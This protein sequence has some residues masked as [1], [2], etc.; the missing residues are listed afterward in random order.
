MDVGTAR[1]R[2]DASVAAEQ[3]IPV[4]TIGPGLH[5]EKEP[6]QRRAVAYCCGR[7][8][9][10]LSGIFDVAVH[11]INRPSE[12]RAQNEREKHPIFDCDKSR[13]RKEIE[14]NILV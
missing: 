11:P 1:A 12:D 10:T 14:S 2:N 5:S 13:Q 4:E 8:R 6:E 3:P 7:Y 9:P